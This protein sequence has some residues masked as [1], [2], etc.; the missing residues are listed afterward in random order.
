MAT[1]DERSKDEKSDSERRM[2]EWRAEKCR[3]LITYDPKGPENNSNTKGTTSMSTHRE[4]SCGCPYRPLTPV[5]GY[6]EQTGHMKRCRRH[7]QIVMDLETVEVSEGKRG[8]LMNLWVGGD[9]VRFEPFPGMTQ[10]AQISVPEGWWLE[11]CRFDGV[12]LA[13]ES[14]AD[15]TA[16]EVH[17]RARRMRDGF[18]MVMNE[19]EIEAARRRLA[20]AEADRPGPDGSDDWNTEA[21][22]GG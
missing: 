14:S 17:L 15:L 10:C 4:R 20:A 8:T 22:T 11:S 2:D 16:Y 18:R 12:I 13:N 3:T 19:R 21:S 9:T 1:D 5:A 6:S 7:K